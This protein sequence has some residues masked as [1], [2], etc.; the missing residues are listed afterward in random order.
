MSE[1]ALL[2]QTTIAAATSATGTSQRLPTNTESLI[3]QAMFT[4]GSGGTNVTAYV[5]TSF[6]DGDY[7]HDIAS[8]QF[9][10]ATARK[11]SK[12]ISTAALTANTT[13]TDGAL[14]INTILDGVLG[15]HVRVKYV[16]TG[17]YSGTTHLTVTGFALRGLR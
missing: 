2:A 4:Y 8:F 10:T 16:S 13:T 6:D 11:L 5:Q 9:T 7:W 3:V 1:V 14:T 12:V 17:T 15:R